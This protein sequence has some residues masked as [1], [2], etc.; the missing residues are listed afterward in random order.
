L[1]LSSD[2]FKAIK[3]T[4]VNQVIDILR[5]KA[6]AE[7]KLLLRYHQQLR[8]EK[9]LVDLS[10]EI[11]KE[12]NDVTDCL[13]V[14]LGARKS[15]VLGT[16]MFH[17]I[18]YRHC[19]AVLVEKYKDRILKRLPEAHQIAI[20]SAFIASYIVYREG[21]GWLNSIPETLRY[22]A[23]RSYMES[24]LMAQTMISAIKDSNVHGKDEI[25]IILSRSAARHLAMHEIEKAGKSDSDK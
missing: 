20:L 2:E 17:D 15:E 1:T 13:L 11:S 4:Y 25:A 3:P 7:A 8:G 19:P 14:E 23:A 10:M 12:I 16:K 21:L 6:D 9:T 18:I 22:K 5:Q 24:D